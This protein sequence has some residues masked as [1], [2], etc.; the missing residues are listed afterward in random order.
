[1]AELCERHGVSRPTGYKRL[2]RFGDEGEEGV[3]RGCVSR[4]AVRI[5][6]QLAWRR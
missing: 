5:V 4:E 3:P 1:M 2:K 6:R